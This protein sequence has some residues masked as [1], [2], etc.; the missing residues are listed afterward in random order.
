MEAASIGINPCRHCGETQNCRRIECEAWRTFAGKSGE[1][2]KA[3]REDE[4]VPA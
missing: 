2:E 1:E 4:A 3:T